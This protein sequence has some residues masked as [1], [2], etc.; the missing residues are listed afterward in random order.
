M[1]VPEAAGV[2]GAGD[3]P[4][5][6]AWQRRSGQQGGGDHE[7]DGQGPG[8]ISQRAT[9]DHRIHSFTAIMAHIVYVYYNVPARNVNFSEALCKILSNPRRCIP[10]EARA[11]AGQGICGLQGPRNPKRIRN[12]QRA[13]GANGAESGLPKAYRA[14]AGRGPG[15]GAT[16]PWSRV[17]SVLRGAQVNGTGATRAS[18][19]PP[20]PGLLPGAVSYG[21]PGPNRRFPQ[22]KRRAM[23]P[24]ERAWR[25]FIWG[26]AAY[27]SA[28][29][30]VEP[31]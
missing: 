20:T 2:A 11:A 3:A 22:N 13:T 27:A 5:S 12:R 15:A 7:K 6:Q 9:L 14:L 26:W 30:S 1:G 25:A 19:S 21:S 28:T 4:G 24:P 29:G 17:A 8:G 18:G 23:E 16:A 31:P 10:G